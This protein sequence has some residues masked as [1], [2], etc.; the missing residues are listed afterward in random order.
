MSDKYN[1]RFPRLDGGREQG[2]NNSGITTFKGSELYDNLA[3]EI[4]QNSLDAK[5]EDSTE[6]VKVSFKVKV[7][8]KTSHHALQKLEDIFHKCCEY[9]HDRMN[10]KMG[11]F[12]E[13]AN[14]I[15]NS[16]S[17]HFLVI[18]DYNTTGLVGVEAGKSDKSAWRSLVDSDGDSDKGSGSGGSYGIGKNAPFACSQLRTVFYNT[19]AA[20]DIK[21]FQG[22]AMLFTHTSEENED[23]VGSGAYKN[24]SENTPVFKS[25][26]CSFINEFPR[27]DFGTDVIIAGYNQ[28]NNWQE[29]IEIAVLKNFFASILDN[30]LV[31]EIDEEIIVDRSTILSRLDKYINST[32][33]KEIIEAKQ[34]YETITEYDEFEKYTII[35]PDDLTVYVKLNEDYCR[36]IAEMRSIRMLVNART[37]TYMSNYAA[38]AVATGSELNEL[39][40]TMEP[41][42]HDKWDPGLHYKESGIKECR[43]ILIKI[44]ECEHKT[45][46]KI[47]KTD[48]SDSIDPDGIGNFLPDDFDMLPEASKNNPLEY[49]DDSDISNEK[50]TPITLNKQTIVAKPETGKKD[51]GNPSDDNNGGTKE[52][53]DESG[54][55]DD[56]NED[57]IYSKGDGDKKVEIQVKYLRAL[58][59]SPANGVYKVVLLP[60]EDALNVFFSFNAVGDDSSEEELKIKRVITDGVSKVINSMSIGPFDLYKESKLIFDVVFDTKERILIN[61][62]AEVRANDSKKQ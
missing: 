27:I 47:I 16:D 39:L 8:K 7:I 9:W 42:K 53:T 40:R 52:G 44:R 46:E 33:N 12:F 10:E 3:R 13:R 38:V 22:V 30:K 36:K 37:K 45:I 2:F 15:F 11:D 26:D 14:D 54:E 49:S 35:E 60:V 21:A 58:P 1:W 17:I 43:K 28:S 61:T 20:D 4:C 24:I 56:D 32:G 5:T 48:K 55:K 6:P 51:G 59:V 62:N 57:D 23:T 29:E 18:S 50:Q 19:Y 25:N 41:P 34:F 31:V